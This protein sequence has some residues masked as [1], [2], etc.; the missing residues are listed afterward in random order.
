MSALKLALKQQ[1][2]GRITRDKDIDSLV[3]ELEQKQQK[4]D[5]SPFKEPLEECGDQED[6]LVRGSGEMSKPITTLLKEWE[7]TEL[8]GFQKVHK[9]EWQCQFC[10][11]KDKEWRAVGPCTC[12][13]DCFYCRQC[14]NMGRVK[15]CTTLYALADEAYSFPKKSVKVIYRGELSPSQQMISTALTDFLKQSKQQTCLVWAVTGAGKTE[16]IFKA[17]Q[18]VLEAGGRV[19]LAAPRIDVCHE[20][21]PRI[22]TAFPFVEQVCLTSESEDSYRRVPLTILTTH[23][24]LRFYQA[25]D[26]LVIDEVDAFP[27]SNQPMLVYG[28]RRSLQLTGKCIYLTATPSKALQKATTNQ[29]I[30]S[31]VLPARYHRHPLVV[32]KVKWCGNWRKLLSRELLPQFLK[33]WIRQHLTTKKRFLLFVPSIKMI[34]Q[35]EKSLQKAFPDAEFSSVSS[36]EEK[37]SKRVM[38]MR[39]EEYDFLVTTTILERGVT[40][41]NIDVLVLGAED[42]IFTKEVLIQI[43][44]R[45]GRTVDY[46][47]GEVVFCHYGTTKAIKQAVKEINNLNQQAFEKGMIDHE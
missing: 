29:E 43:A 16:M 15:C 21:A 23:Q 46:P 27:Y 13:E 3:Y 12:G 31:L 30:A 17:I 26:L 39:Q 1:L 42:R 10:G 25:F 45:A 32:P 20:L 4:A 7:V 28:A 41:P 47:T 8:A 34:P 35:I 24:L 9:R 19:G 2:Q 5:V 37:R 40:F 11:T 14:F 6:S 44:G 33:K 18:Q 36:K 22:K 38:K